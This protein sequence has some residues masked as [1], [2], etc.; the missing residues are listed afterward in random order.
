MAKFGNPLQ[1]L[2]II[3]KRLDHF[4]N[5]FLYQL[6][7]W[8]PPLCIYW[9][10]PWEQSQAKPNGRYTGEMFQDP[11][12]I[13]TR[14]ADWDGNPSLLCHL[15][16]VVPSLRSG[17]LVHKRWLRLKETMFTTGPGTCYV[18]PSPPA[19]EQMGPMSTA[20][21]LTLQSSVYSLYVMTGKWPEKSI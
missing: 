6:D 3:M 2:R 21:A 14:Q 19:P 1:G 7:I 5:F 13:H 20:H 16:L 9:H 4:Q 8:V 11:N 10:L 18:P 15:G 12:Y 17:D